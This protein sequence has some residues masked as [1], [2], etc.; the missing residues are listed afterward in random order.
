MVFTLNF[1]LPKTIFL[2]QLTK[3]S[4]WCFTVL[5]CAPTHGG[6]SEGACCMF[7]F[8]YDGEQYNSCTDMDSSRLWCATTRDYDA[9]QK[10]GHCQSEFTTNIKK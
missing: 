1:D 6:N 2:N 4:G 5:G 3:F 8:S 10:W 9:D 7:P